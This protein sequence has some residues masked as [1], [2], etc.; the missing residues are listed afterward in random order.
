MPQAATEEI[1]R[2]RPQAEPPPPPETA[3]EDDLTEIVGIGPAYA[4]RLA[5]HGITTFAAL[6]GADP[7]E[8]AEVIRVS[9]D[10]VA[11]W[12]KQARARA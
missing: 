12:S 11:D 3:G 6:A 10:Q 7:D 5:E 4:R 8:T 2:F 1:P 9:P